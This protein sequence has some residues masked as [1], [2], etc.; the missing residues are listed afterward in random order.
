M[1][2]AYP[3][4]YALEVV[5]EVKQP[6]RRDFENHLRT[7]WGNRFSIRSFDYEDERRWSIAPDKPVY[8]PIVRVSEEVAPLAPH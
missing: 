2:A 8:Q 5:R 3:H 4:I 7:D 1:L 6:D